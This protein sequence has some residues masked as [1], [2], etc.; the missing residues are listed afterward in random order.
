MENL[1]EKSPE[2]IEFLRTRI[3]PSVQ[4][5]VAEMMIH[6]ALSESE[7]MRVLDQIRDYCF[8]GRA[9][10]E[11]PYKRPKAYLVIA[12]TGA[13]KSNL[14]MKIQRSNP[15][16]VI[17]DSDA[18]KAFNPNK[19][20]IKDKYPQYYGHLT[21]LDAYL[22]RDEIYDEAL[23]EG[24]NI[25]IEVAPS[26][27]DLLFNINF[28]ELIEHGYDIE[29]FILSVSEENSLLSV[30]ERYE[31]QIESGMEAPK[32]TDLKRARDSA[33]A[34]PL[35]INDL[36]D[37]HPE[38]KLV[39]FKRAV[40][41]DKS[42]EVSDP[43]FITE[44]REGF[45]QAYNEAKQDDLARTLEEADRRI[46]VVRNQMSIRGAHPLHVKQFDEICPIISNSKQKS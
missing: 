10:I 29:A 17:I 1:N 46:E 38:V 19:D 12:Q 32:L 30:H 44:K 7:H 2:Y 42:R 31:G 37:N 5:D 3:A 23:K 6:Y 20:E 22:H 14:T 40:I 35:I 25:L 11:R 36:I 8:R 43:I 45:M 41:K 13:G 34:V 21:G 27:R 26:S 28:E 24:Y 9:P 18:F 15:N 39:L 4:P 33:A 16:I